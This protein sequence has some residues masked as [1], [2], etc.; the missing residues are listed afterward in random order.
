[1]LTR[2]GHYYFQTGLNIILCLAA[3]RLIWSGAVTLFGF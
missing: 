1:V 3:L 2:F